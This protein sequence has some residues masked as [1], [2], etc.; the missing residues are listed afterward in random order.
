MSIRSRSD[1]FSIM[2]NAV[3]HFIGRISWARDQSELNEYK[4]LT[5]LQDDPG[6][7][8]MKKKMEWLIRF[9]TSNLKKAPPSSAIVCLLN[10]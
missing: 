5:A 10:P 9:M 1:T 8:A 7:I 3:D 6:L 4:K 2:I